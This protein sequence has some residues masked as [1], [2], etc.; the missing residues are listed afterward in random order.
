MFEYLGAPA[1]FSAASLCRSVCD[2]VF[3]FDVRFFGSGALLVRISATAAQL[4]AN[5]P[6]S[7]SPG[8]YLH[9]C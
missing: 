5:E 7:T 3:A 8:L 6:I 1:A 2:F 9:M 4:E